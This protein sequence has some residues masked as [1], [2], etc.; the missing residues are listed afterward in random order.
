MFDFEKV[1]DGIV[2]AGKEV[3]G[4]AKD[5][6][7]IAKLKYNIHT[8]ESF[9]EKQYALL[10]KAYY[11]A[12]KDEDVDEKV[13]FPSIR[14]AEEELARMREE[15]LEAQGA[16]VCPNCGDKQDAKNGF[17]SSCGATLK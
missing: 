12:H 13:Y 17:C 9:L 3:E 2:N 15:I 10:G 4:L 11:D 8:K 1:K 6:S 16:V 5:V 14:E 7:T